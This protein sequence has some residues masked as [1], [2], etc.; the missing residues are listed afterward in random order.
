M[1]DDHNRPRWSWPLAFFVLNAAAIFGFFL[2][3]FY[4]G[5]STLHVRQLLPFGTEVDPATISEV[6]LDF[7]KPLH[8]ESIGPDTIKFIPP[9]AGHCKLS[10]DGR[11]L[12]FTPREPLRSATTY[13]VFLSPALRGRREEMPPREVLEFSTQRFRLLSASQTGFDRDYYTVELRFNQPIAASDLKSAL[14]IQ[15]FRHDETVEY[16]ER[17]AVMGHN[18]ADTQRLRIPNNAGSHLLLTL[19]AGTTGSSG[20]LG[21]ADTEQLVFQLPGYGNI[22]QTAL[23]AWAK[24]AD[25]VELRSEVAFLGISA[26][27]DDGTGVVRVRMTAQTD[28]EKIGRYIAVDPALPVTFASTWNGFKIM[29]D[30]QPGRQ[31][32]VTLAKGLPASFPKQ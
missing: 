16:G 31:Y 30:F 21:F 24:T 28:L 18:N 29:G 1:N 10:E 7:D 15:A 22:S 32:R 27:W 23:P 11:S 4:P 2:L 26:E 14:R 17:V 12:V 13:S 6:R 5:D 25:V 19:P 9:L 20:A 8:P 3:Y